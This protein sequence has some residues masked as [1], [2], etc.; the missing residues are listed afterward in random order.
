M[1]VDFYFGVITGM[2]IAWLVYSLI[3]ILLSLAKERMVKAGQLKEEVSERPG[4]LTDVLKLSREDA[5]KLGLKLSNPNDFAVTGT[6][7][8]VPWHIRRKELEEAART[9]RKKL[10]SFQEFV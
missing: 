1:N 9:K 5:G 3:S 8:R 7:R 4:E 2:G 10:E 6:P